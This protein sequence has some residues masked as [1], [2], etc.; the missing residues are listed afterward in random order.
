[1]RIVLTGTGMF[2]VLIPYTLNIEIDVGSITDWV[3]A[4]TQLGILIVALYALFPDTPKL[5][6]DVMLRVIVSRAGDG[7]SKPAVVVTVTNMGKVPTRVESISFVRQRLWKRD[8]VWTPLHWTQN[9]TGILLGGYAN[10]HSEEAQ[11]MYHDAMQKIVRE[12]RYDE[13]DALVKMVKKEHSLPRV[14]D[15]S[16]TTEW[17]IEHEGDIRDLLDKYPNRIKVVVST[18]RKSYY[19]KKPIE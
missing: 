14:L 2:E 5:K 8:L 18:S 3:I 7:I 15:P 1:M 12:N 9:A 10:I 19:S 6:V 17:L 11:K 4:I 16:V 13:L